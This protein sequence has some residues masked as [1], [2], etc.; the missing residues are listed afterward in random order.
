MNRRK[1]GFF[2]V[3]IMISL[4]ASSASLAQEPI[5]GYDFKA[6]D[7]PEGWAMAHTLSSALNLGTGPADNLGLFQ[8]QLEAELA[9]IPHLS[10]DQQQV[11][12]GGYKYEDMN[13]SPV[14][15]RARA[16]VGLPAAVTA[17]LSWTPPLTIDGARPKSLFGLALQR[18]IV[19]IGL[20]QLGGRLHAVRGYGSA[21]VSCSRRVASAEPGSAENPL[22]CSGPSIDKLAMDQQGAEIM[23]SRSILNERLQPFVAIA[24]TRF[25]PFVQVEAPIFDTKHFWELESRG[26]VETFTV[27]ARWAANDRWRTGVAFSYT[28]LKVNRPV[29]A[30]GERDD[31]WSIRISAAWRSGQ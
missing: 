18:E 24:V 4:C 23:L 17:E 3:S 2:V 19:R 25:D 30:T 28:P 14:F 16:S 10:K 11:G 6:F 29:A 13:K 31:F 20:W 12:F 15:G 21:D 8:W 9:S 22:S 1:S 5:S 27:G 7:T 26:T